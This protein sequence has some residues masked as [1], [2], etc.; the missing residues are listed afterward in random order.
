MP[1]TNGGLRCAALDPV[2]AR[3]VA[4]SPGLSLIVCHPERRGSR[5]PASPRLHRSL[6]IGG[7][8]RAAAVASSISESSAYRLLRDESVLQAI[9]ERQAAGD[10]E[11]AYQVVENMRTAVQ[12]LGE[13]LEDW[14]V[15]Q[16]NPFARLAA[17]RLAVQAFDDQRISELTAEVTRFGWRP[18][19]RKPVAP[20]STSPTWSGASGSRGPAAA[21]SGMSESRVGATKGDRPPGGANRRARP[22]PTARP[23]ESRDGRSPPQVSPGPGQCRG[24]PQLPK[25]G[26]W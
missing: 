25:S 14:T 13:L 24:S 5:R 19:K 21:A 2:P 9:A 23:C 26:A 20:S 16:S 6:R 10:A 17:I 22:H 18:G 11:I 3:E 8:V 7:E 1:D 12:A 4:G 15:C